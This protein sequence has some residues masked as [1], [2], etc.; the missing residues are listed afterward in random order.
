M[1]KPLP[2]RGHRGVLQTKALL[3]LALCLLSDQSQ[4][5]FRERGVDHENLLQVREGLEGLCTS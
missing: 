2:A 3:C 5:H 1:A 4:F